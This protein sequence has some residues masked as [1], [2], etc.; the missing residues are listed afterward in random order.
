VVHSQ[1]HGIAL[2]Q[3]HNLR[4]RL[5]SGT[6]FGHYK[7]TAGE[8]SAR[9]RK[10]K[11]HL[12]GKYVFSVKILMEAVATARLVLKNQWRRTGLA[13]CMASLDEFG[14][15]RRVAIAVPR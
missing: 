8:I 13:R 6:L 9:L 7:F 10:Q 12:N 3:R 1:C 5:H 11:R 14:V 4:P 15:F 2:E